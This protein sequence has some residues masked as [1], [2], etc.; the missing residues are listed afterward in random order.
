MLP[1]FGSL[2]RHLEFL[3]IA[4]GGVVDHLHRALLPFEHD[5]V[6]LFTFLDIWRQLAQVAR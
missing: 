5:P 6:V 3:R 4:T 1:H 2:G